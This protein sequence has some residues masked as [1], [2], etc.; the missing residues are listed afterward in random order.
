[1]SEPDNTIRTLVDD[2]TPIGKPTH[3][4]RSALLWLSLAMLATGGT[5][6]LIQPFRPGFVEQFLT[7]PRFAVEIILGLIVCAGL[8]YAAFQ[9]GIPDIRSPW[10]RA[11][12][13][14]LLLTIWLAL[15]AIAI[16]APVFAPSMA[17]KRPLCYLEV[18]IYAAPLSLAGLLLIR[19]MLPLEPVTV[20]AWM[21]FAAGLIPAFLMQL[22]CMH[23]PIH[24]I[25]WHLLPT[26]GAAAIGA[27]L[28]FWLLR[29]G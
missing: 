1:M 20:G 11:R 26:L 24:N 14:L 8:A 4:G 19:R 28:G 10:R 17:G 29:R 16:F 7:T 18:I 13:P 3:S 25:A 6:A 23:G 27:L 15:F 2:L 21:G 9:L 5:M 22:A 12:V